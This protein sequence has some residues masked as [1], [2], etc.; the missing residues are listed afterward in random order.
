MH[1]KN[2]LAKIA[3][4]PALGVVIGLFILVFGALA[5][6]AAV[7]HTL[8]HNADARSSS[9]AICSLVKGQIGAADAPIVTSQPAVFVEV[10]VIPVSSSVPHAP[11]ILLPPGRAPPVSA[12]AS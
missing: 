2:K 6:G 12:V 7:Y 3:A 9:C 5:S 11:S 4:R 1:L 8:H 10:A